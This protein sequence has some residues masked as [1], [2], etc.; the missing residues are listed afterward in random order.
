M[1]AALVF[2]INNEQDIPELQA[3]FNIGPHPKND[4][5]AKFGFLAMRYFNQIMENF[6]IE[7]NPGT[8]NIK[9]C[10]VF[11]YFPENIPKPDENFYFD[12]EK[13]NN[14]LSKTDIIK[15][16]KNI[17]FSLFLDNYDVIGGMS[18]PTVVVA[19]SIFKLLND[20]TSQAAIIQ[21]NEFE[22]DEDFY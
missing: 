18:E 21:D 5:V 15:D 4:I 12:N 1:T 8:K 10:I 3:N 7:Y 16:S 17:S 9:A 14:V 2:S 22:D 6:E 20:A 11:D 19:T 13:I